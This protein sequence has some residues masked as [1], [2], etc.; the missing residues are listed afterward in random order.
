MSNSTVN[1]SDAFEF[2]VVLVGVILVFKRI[3]D[4][5]GYHLERV[6]ILTAILSIG[7]IY[8]FLGLGVTF[9]GLGPQSCVVEFSEPGYQF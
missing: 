8:L 3:V 9:G 6:I 7:A 4:I 2:V 1:P 5:D